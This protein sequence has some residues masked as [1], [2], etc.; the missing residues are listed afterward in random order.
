MKHPSHISRHTILAVL[1]SFVDA[2]KKKKN[3]QR[4]H[5]NWEAIFLEHCIWPKVQALRISSKGLEFFYKSRTFNIRL[6]TPYT[7]Q[8]N[9]CLVETQHENDMRQKTGLISAELDT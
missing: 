8:N 6:V 5:A 3:V 9:S 7:K 2:K 4:L 1:F